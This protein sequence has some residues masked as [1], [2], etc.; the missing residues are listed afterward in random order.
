MQTK[1]EKFLNILACILSCYW[2][3]E[4]E[5]CASF[6]YREEVGAV[7]DT[8]DE[9][10]LSFQLSRC[11]DRA[12]NFSSKVP[13]SSYFSLLMVPWCGISR[14]FRVWAIHHRWG[15]Q[16]PGSWTTK[17]S[18]SQISAISMKPSCI[19][20]HHQMSWFAQTNP[21]GEQSPLTDKWLT[22]CKFLLHIPQS[23]F[24]RP[25]K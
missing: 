10:S 4:N 14:L 20:T 17:K 22:K 8:S 21:T 6:V 2:Q 19:T 11:R 18:N 15:W 3:E 9:I 24:E 1:K 13:L 5:A 16:W 7:D 23:E 25:L 12:C